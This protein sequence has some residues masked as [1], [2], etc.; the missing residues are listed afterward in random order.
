M[1][2]GRTVQAE[3]P[4]TEELRLEDSPKVA[5]PE[6]RTVQPQVVQTTEKGMVI[7]RVLRRPPSLR[8]EEVTRI[9][10]PKAR[11]NLGEASPLRQRGA[12]RAAHRLGKEPPLAIYDLV[13]LLFHHRW[14]LLARLTKLRLPGRSAKR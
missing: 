1:T 5:E 4:E 9:A 2:R 3:V 7:G 11:R 6:A 13:I 14:N 8:E 10:A 12:E